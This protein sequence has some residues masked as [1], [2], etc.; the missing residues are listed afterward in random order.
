V[1]GRPLKLVAYTDAD[2]IGGAELSLAYLLGSLARDVDVTVVGVDDDVVRAI[3][4]HRPG[5]ATVVLPPVHNRYDIGPILRHISAIR[6]LRPDICQANLRTPFSCQYGILAA[7]LTPGAR[8]VVVEHLPMPTSSGLRRWLKRR[9]ARRAS[10]HV[11]VGERSARLIEQQV[12][13]PPGSVRTIYNGIPDVDIEPLPR[14]RDGVVIGFTGRFVEQ[15]GLE[16]LLDAVALVDD[17]TLVLVG[18]GPEREALESRARELGIENRVV[19]TG[20]TS[21]AR[22]HLSTFDVF[23]LPSR[24]EGFPLVLLEAMLAGLPTVATDVGS[25]AESVVDG[26]TGVIVA[27]DDSRALAS[28]L[29]RLLDDEELRT[30]MGDRGRERARRWFTAETMA[31]SYEL[32]YREL[33]P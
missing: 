16:T 26:E 15:K 5:T 20:W 19:M 25:V 21:D 29:Q 18:D 24:F 31:G 22:R 14:P 30:K 8:V 28:A 17:A 32:L 33:A 4:E 27:P 12:R 13:L 6:R 7:L 11:S 1:S 3:A 23:A 2:T 9:L 10:A